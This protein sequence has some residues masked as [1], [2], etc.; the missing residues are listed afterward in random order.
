MSDLCR[1][2]LMEFEEINSL[3][4]TISLRHQ[5][6]VSNREAKNFLVVDLDLH[7]ATDNNRHRHITGC[8][9]GDEEG[10]RMSHGILDPF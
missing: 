2:R 5:Q 1:F 8:T 7:G 9:K 6:A 10:D 4:L 3:M